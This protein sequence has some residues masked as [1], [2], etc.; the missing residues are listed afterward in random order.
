MADWTTIADSQ[1]DP[2]AP[3]T[4]ELMSALRDNP[5]AIAE[6][7]S[8]APKIN[9]IAAFAHGGNVGGV[10]TYV[11]A[12]NTTTTN[13][14]GNGT[15]AGSNLRYRSTGSGAGNTFTNIS[16]DNNSTF[17]TSGTST[18]SGTWRAMQACSG[19]TEAS[20]GPGETRYS[21]FPSLWLRIS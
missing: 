9:P 10:G 8:G 5:V 21:W 17:P 4:S 7:A 18:L 1:V 6:G 2:N 19:R 20:I 16:L 3:V 12:W 13:I 15:I 11:A 14:D